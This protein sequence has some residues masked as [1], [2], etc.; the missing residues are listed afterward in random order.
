MILGIIIGT[1][2][3][4]Y[5]TYSQLIFRFILKNI[6]TLLSILFIVTAINLFD[7]LSDILAIVFFIGCFFALGAHKQALHDIIAKTSIYYK[8]ELQQLSNNN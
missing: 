2:D 6:N 7:T 3:K 1:N 4:K 5:S 8:D